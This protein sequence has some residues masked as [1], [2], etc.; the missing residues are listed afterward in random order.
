[1]FSILLRSKGVKRPR[2]TMQKFIVFQNIVIQLKKKI[3][4]LATYKEK[5]KKEKE[6]RRRD[7][8]K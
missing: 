3:K 2:V 1:M 7:L 5:R 8:S 4:E 6:K